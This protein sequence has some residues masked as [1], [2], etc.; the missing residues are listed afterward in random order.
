MLYYVDL[1]V[2]LVHRW[3]ERS[4]TASYTFVFLQVKANIDLET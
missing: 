1:G 2:L 4:C 3:A